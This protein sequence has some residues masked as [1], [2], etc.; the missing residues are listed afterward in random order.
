MAPSEATILSNFL[1]VPAQ[2]TAII[3]LEEFTALFPRSQRS[4]PQI[5]TLYRDLQNQRNEIRDVV[6]ANI[7]NEVK[8]AK[9]LRRAV[10]KAR[11]DAETHDYDD[12]IEI[13]REVICFPPNC[14]LG[15]RSRRF[16]DR[17]LRIRIDT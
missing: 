10:I 2:L 4:S 9:Y 3:S 15:L 8:E 16:T 7:E 13:E 17:G 1:L 12:E 6:A 14:R 5:R 11:K